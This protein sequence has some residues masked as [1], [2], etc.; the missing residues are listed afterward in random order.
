LGDDVI[1]VRDQYYILST[2]SLTDDRIHVLKEG[3]TFAV[4]D[5]RGDIEPIGQASHGLYHHETRFL[6]QWVLR[7]GRERPLLLSSA[8]TDD[9]ALLAVDL[10]NPDIHTNG[11]VIVPRGTLHISR[12][13]FLW[14]GTQ[15]E[16][17]RIANYSLKPVEISFSL[18]FGG[19]FA[20]IFEVRGL[21]RKRRGEYLIKENA[22]ESSIILSYRGL[23]G[24]V[25]R[26][27]L[28][29]SPSPQFISSTEMSVRVALA[30]SAEQ[31]YFLAV[32]CEAGEEIVRPAG[33]NSAFVDVG[34]ALQEARNREPQIYTSNEW[35]NDW[36]NRSAADIHMMMTETLY[37]PYPYAGVPWFSTV[38]GRDGIITAIETL[39]MNPALAQ[40][41]LSY[42]AATQAADSTPEVDA[43][44]GKI[45]HES[46][47]GEMAILKEIPFRCYYGSV[48]STPLFVMLAGK[49]YRR[50]GDL[51]FIE[52]IWPSIERALDWID[53]YGDVDGDGFVEYARRSAKGLIQQGWKDSSDSVFHRD[54]ALAEGPIALCEVQ[55]Y[56]YAAKCE[57]GQMAMALGKDRQAQEFGQEAQELR[58]RFEHAFWC[59][60][61]ST[62]ALALDGN[63]QPCQVCTSNAGHCLFSG[64]ASQERAELVSRTLLDPES[65]SGWGIRTLSAQEVRY[66]PMSYHNGSIWPHDNALIAWGMAR[67]GLKPFLAKIFSG[68]LDASSSVDLH[69][70]PEL[71]CGFNRRPGEGPTLYPVAC[72]PQSWAAASVFLLLEACLGISIE[73]QHGQ[74]SF[75]HSYLPESLHR[76]SITNLWVGSASVDL[77]IQRFGDSVDVSVSRKQ[78]EVDV[79]CGK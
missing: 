73:A 79:V 39:W 53:H 11:E 1:R 47:Q 3:D 41:V 7:L 17:L 50:T 37:G 48:D 55:G 24:V 21:K 22:N 62:Y 32:S 69:R 13:R 75:A 68:L 57:A 9:N 42:L 44:P 27:H 19:D 63:K 6:S 67:Y 18:Q 35:F 76:V 12:S 78:G 54:G 34:S 8:V 40:G 33:Y 46:R 5:R 10:T 31:T 61:L 36:L 30:P 25:R 16:R 74:I 45:L 43:E 15:Y 60:E 49:Y 66:N 72:S 59:E 71:F 70:L 26:T 29:C 64:I 51:A 52:S 38:F 4:Y 2:S 58:R 56:V 23:D 65:F 14:K 77:S 20:D 28:E